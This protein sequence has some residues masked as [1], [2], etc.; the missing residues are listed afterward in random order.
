LPDLLF[1]LD[2]EGRYLRVLTPKTEWLVLESAQLLGKTV[3]EVMPPAA[4]EVVHQALRDAEKLG[5][6]WGR[7]LALDVPDGAQWFEISVAHKDSPDGDRA[8][9]IVISRNVTPRKRLR[10]A[11]SCSTRSWRCAWRHVPLS[12]P[13]PGRRR[14]C[15]SQQERLPV[16]DEP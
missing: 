12:S 1:E 7:E 13:R 9:Y 6:V 5:A 14:A 2:G 11:S 15:Q 10:S 3:R 8:T 4:A 16:A